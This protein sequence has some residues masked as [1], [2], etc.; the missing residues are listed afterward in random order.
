MLL[1]Q[2]FQSQQTQQRYRV[3]LEHIDWLMLIDIDD[4]NAWPFL[5]TEQTFQ[6]SEFKPIE[7]PFPLPNVEPESVAQAKRDEA[8]AVLEPLL[9]QYLSLFDKSERNARIKM[10]LTQIDKPRLYVTRQLRRYWQ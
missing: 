3:V 7:D 8:F 6:Q 5:M 4:V 10:L 1:N 2:V 9:S